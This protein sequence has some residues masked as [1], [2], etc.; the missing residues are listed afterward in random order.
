MLPWAPGGER[1]AAPA[2]WV[3]GKRKP[4]E[5]ARTKSGRNEETRCAGAPSAQG[6]ERRRPSPLRDP[7]TLSVAR[8]PP[9]S[10]CSWLQPSESRNFSGPYRPLSVGPPPHRPRGFLLRFR[11]AHPAPPPPALHAFPATPGAWRAPSASQLPAAD[12][13]LPPCTHRELVEPGEETAP[14]P[15]EAGGEKASPQQPRCRGERRQRHRP[16]QEQPP[17]PHARPLSSAEGAVTATQ[18]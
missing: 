17:G 10:S 7:R 15:S 8:P 4:R 1:P 2:I 9:G 6:P 14:H 12:P 5:R 11:A 16:A 18:P 13:G 3:G